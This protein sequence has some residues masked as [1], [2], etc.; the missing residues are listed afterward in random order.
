M[1]LEEKLKQLPNDAGVY[2]Y[3]DKD[4]RLLYIGKAKVLK[5]RVKSYFKFTPKLLPSDKLGPR[6]Y[7][8]ISQTAWIEW[9]VVPN[10]HDALILENSLIKQLKPK[11]NILLRDDKTYP[12]IYIDYTEL[13][14]R[15]EITRKVYKNKN[16]KYF[17]PYSTG[18]RDML[19]SIYEIVPLVQ[20]KSCIK[21]KEAC[22]FHQIKR[23]H[24][25]C[26][27]KISTAE[28]S[29]IV[30]TAIDYIYN[31][32][33]LISKLQEKMMEYSEDFR[34]EEAMKLRDRIKTIEK[35]QIKSGVDLAT[36]ENID[37]F[38]IKASNKKAVVVRMFIRDGKLTSSSYDF[39]KINFLDEDL[40]IDLDE[41][42]KR[43][44][45]NYYDNEI[46]VLPKE[47]LTGIELEDKEDIEEFLY[48]KFSKKI[49]IVH[50]KKDKKK[51][52]V[53]IALNNCDELLR[54]DSSRNQTTIYDELKKLFSLQTIPS[55]IESY[56]N[57]HMMGQATVGAMVVW[58][59]EIN[60]FERKDFRHY[61]LE[62]KDEYSQMREMLIRRVESFEKNPAPDLWV[63]DGGS[64]LLKL[65]YDIVNSSGV[66]LDVIAIAKEKVDAKAHRAKGAAKDIVHYKDEKGEYRA[67][68]LE[69]SD[70]RLQFVQRQ[71][72]EAHRFVINFHKKQKRKEDKQISL[73][74]IKGIGE[75][76]VKKLLLY[77]GE[78][79][80]IR[81][82]SI[83]DLK[84]VLNE[85]DATVISNYFKENE[86]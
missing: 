58:N 57:S 25:P 85:K 17:G 44:I 10:E 49:K 56:D 55:R 21:G 18:A 62:S 63:I 72:D 7:R 73:L 26:E 46:P 43:A 41:A 29:K 30:D 81:S 60:G 34:F 53:K 16:I 11:Y 5:N 28:Y 74:Q 32:S 61:N 82:A 4:G 23:C 69:T 22:L 86:D 83:E 38:A 35:S 64:T 3:F 40:N 36:N 78:F 76:K 79:E 37:L 54:I 27:G 15:L 6:I 1:Q 9:I 80:K 14:P 50:P 52:L 59:D 12:Y 48:N 8:M 77:F 20:K 2:Q 47:V 42:Y 84:E 51:D 45:I 71:R 68:K 24:A 33:K 31:K 39:I 67:L 70:Q 19:D 13:F 66:N 65:A 75:A